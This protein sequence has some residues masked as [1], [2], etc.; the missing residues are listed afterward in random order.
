MYEKLSV[1]RRTAEEAAATRRALL[2]AALAEF[3]ELGYA[4]ATLAGIA[5]RAGVTRGALYHHFTDKAAL[6]LS[7]ISEL[8]AE[9]A[10][11][12]WNKLDGPEP[13]LRRVADFLIAFFTALEE[14]ATFREVFALSMRSAE[15]APELERGLHDKQA[16]M[17]G[18][19]QQMVQLLSKAELRPGITPNTAALAIITAVNGTA[20]TW[21]ACPAL[22]SPAQQAQSLADAILHGFAKPRNTAQ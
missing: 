11:P 2:V 8:W 18:W 13:P 3:A 22:F 12:V 17:E 19:R 20:A 6:C 14:D 4:A 9:A 16:I 1:M 7:A 21:L 5:A 15:G 10:T